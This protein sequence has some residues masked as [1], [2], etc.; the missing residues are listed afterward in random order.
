MMT[1]K[2]IALRAFVLVFLLVKVLQSIL[3]VSFFTKKTAL[4]STSILLNRFLCCI[5]HFA[6]VPSPFALRKD[7]VLRNDFE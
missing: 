2:L 5:A 1:E 4:A 6:R 3:F 7:I